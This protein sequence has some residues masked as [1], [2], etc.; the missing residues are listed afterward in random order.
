MPNSEKLRLLADWFDKKDK[1]NNEPNNEV[2]EDLRRISDFLE[3]CEIRKDNPHDYAPFS[4]NHSLN[5]DSLAQNEY[6][7]PNGQMYKTGNI[8][9]KAASYIRYLEQKL[10][11]NMVKYIENPCE[12][13]RR[14]V[15]K[16][17]RPGYDI[18]VE[19]NVTEGYDVNCQYSVS[20]NN[21]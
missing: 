1:E 8:L 15:L 5:L 14:I 12:T 11:Q 4:E 21:E 6:I 17:S 10:D 2:Q 3:S 18:F 9:L 19:E 20:V 13:S 7:A 16:S